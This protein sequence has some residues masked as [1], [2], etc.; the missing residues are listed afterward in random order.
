[1]MR[2]L[3]SGRPMPVSDI[4]ILR[5]CVFLFNWAFFDGR[6]FGLLQVSWTPRRG[7]STESEISVGRRSSSREFKLQ[8]VKL[9]R[10]LHLE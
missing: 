4:V 5:S 6:G 8:V 2:G 7:I 9:V 3:G 1:M 10:D